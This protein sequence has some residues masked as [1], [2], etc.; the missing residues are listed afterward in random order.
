MFRRIEL[1][2]AAAFPELKIFQPGGPLHED[3]VNITKAYAFYRSDQGYI[4]GTQAVAATLLI[5]LSAVESFVA[6]VNTL[7]RPLPMAFLSGDA[8]S[9][10][11]LDFV[12]L[13]VETQ[14]LRHIR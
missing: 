12:K 14:I 7:N 1:D 3:L 11:D 4:P 2:A 5:N 10:S 9:V 8:I 6:M 13:I